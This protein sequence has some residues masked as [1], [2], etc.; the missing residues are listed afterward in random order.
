MDCMNV[1]LVR[2]WV[3]VGC[4]CGLRFLVDGDG[5]GMFIQNGI[6]LHVYEK[7]WDRL[8]T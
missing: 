6:V 2:I 8:A 7:P 4:E 5:V 3:N 1:V